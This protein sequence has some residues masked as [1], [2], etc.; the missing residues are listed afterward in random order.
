MLKPLKKFFLPPKFNDET[1]NNKARYL[2]VI[3]NVSIALLSL[4]IIVAI[5]D[6]ER[7]TTNLVLGGLVITMLAMEWILR[8]GKIELVAFLLM[9]LTWLAMTYMAWNADGVRNASLIAYLSVILIATLLGNTNISIFFTLLSIASFWFF[10]YAEKQGIITPGLDTPT[11]L[12]RDLSFIFII[13]QVILYLT[14][15]NLN[16]ALGHSKESEEKLS[17]RNQ[18]LIHLQENLEKTVEKRTIELE[19]SAEN[20]QKQTKQLQTISAVSEK[21]ALVQN[22]EELLPEIT[23]LTSK[24][25]GFYHVGIFLISP[26]GNFAQLKAANSEG[27][28]RM[29]ARNHQLEVGKMGIVGRVANDGKSRIALNVGSD[30]VYFDNPDLPETRSEMALPL[31]YGD[32]IVGVLDVQSKVENAFSEEDLETFGTLA[33]QIAIAIENTRQLERTQNALQEMEEVSRQ[34]IRQEWTQLRQRQQETGYRYL[35]GNVEKITPE[36][37]SKTEQTKNTLSIP[38][39]LRDEIIGVLKIRAQENNHTWQ[40]D[41]LELVQAIAD[42][43]ALALENARLLENTSRRAGRERL[44]SEI[45]TK[46]RSTTDP[47]EMITTTLRELKKALN[48]NKVEMM[49][50]TPKED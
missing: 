18:E 48:V 6:P 21:I 8:R 49:P 7:K 38:V 9:A 23:F 24:S 29:L 20:L 4:L 25:F 22:L 17:S 2:H 11:N 34:Y 15:Q 14:V 12:A 10:V 26:D 39:K 44:V 46:I 31:V 33:N 40:E 16:R 5:S 27:G 36:Q 37:Q 47:Q 45:T 32:S 35:Q 30:A 50:Q 42:R 43:A 13:L 41:D 1:Q 19:K 28:K 3:L